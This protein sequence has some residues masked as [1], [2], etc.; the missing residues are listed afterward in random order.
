MR[1]SVVLFLLVAACGTPQ[2]R[3]IARETRDVRVLD[4]LIVES[5]GNLKRGYALEEV[6]TYRDRWVRCPAPPVPAP[7]EGQPAPPPPPPQLCLDEVRETVTRPKSIDLRAEAQKLA[8]MK[9]NRAAQMRAAGPAIAQC[10]AQFP[11]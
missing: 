3:C 9:E 7:E 6:V 5:E 11:E 10:R 1:R 4:R 2:E 8:S